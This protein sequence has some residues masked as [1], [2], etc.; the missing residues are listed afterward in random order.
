M[1]Q[2]ISVTRI[3][4][5]GIVKKRVGVVRGA[6]GTCTC[7]YILGR[8]RQLR[9]FFLLMYVNGKQLGE[10]KHGVGSLGKSASRPF[11]PDAIC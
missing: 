9:V 1:P 8:Q 10:L 3:G 2:L 7:I 6:G 11:R 5:F 4:N